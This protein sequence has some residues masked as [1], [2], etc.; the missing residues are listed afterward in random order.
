MNKYITNGI[1]LMSA[2]MLCL[3]CQQNAVTKDEE[4]IYDKTDAYVLDMMDSLDIIGLNY[5]V[6][7]DG[8]L[9]HKKAFGLA[10]YEHEVPMTQDHLFAVASM[11][12]LF[13]SMAL[14]KLLK[15][16]NRNVNETVSEFLPERKDL[17]VSWT[18]SSLK[19]L[20]SHSSGIPDQ[21]DYQIYLAPDS[22]DVVIEALQNKPFSS[23]PGETNK[24]N[25][26]G[27]LL[28]RMIIEEL[29]GQDFE[30]YMQENYFDQLNLSKANYGGFKKVV[31]H[32]VKSYR[33]V[34]EHLEMFPLNYSSP[35]Y[36]A[37]GLNI[38]MEE[39][40]VW[41]QAVLDGKII[42]KEELTP[43]WK[44]VVLNNGK[45]GYFGLGWHTYELGNGISMTGHG[46]A[47]ISVIRH[48]YKENSKETV[49]VI[50]L[51]N[52]ARNWLKSPDDVNMGIA[53]FFMPGVLD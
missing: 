11:S 40:V 38:N 43:I 22:E 42:S 49:T 17:P 52:G 7:I 35:M 14:H 46:G 26:T 9:M 30:S 50:L 6:L 45:P 39:L 29:A 27:F 3:S 23:A 25:A 16:N 32:R 36:A 31:P 28:I 15:D 1:I 8:K 2:A 12:K 51:T 4:S 41:T 53:N 37:A 48:Y 33:M 24:Y 44:P 47:G 19:S 13:S 18:A 5:C 10:N 34:G 20:L 21:I